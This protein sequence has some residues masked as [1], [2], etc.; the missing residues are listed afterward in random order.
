M[1]SKKTQPEA[2]AAVATQTAGAAQTE[3]Q[4]ESALA[5][6]GH[7][8]RHSIGLDKKPDNVACDLPK[9]HG[10]DHE[11]EHEEYVKEYDTRIENGIEITRTILVAV[12]RRVQWGDMAGIPFSQIP[13]PLPPAP[14]TVANLEKR[15]RSLEALQGQDPDKFINS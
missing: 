9:G 10:G 12:K 1:P 8:N 14:P 4:K 11:G 7:V 2:D 3:A 13:R 15:L 5:A 6:C